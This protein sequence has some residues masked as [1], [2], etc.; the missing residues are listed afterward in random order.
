MDD[1]FGT[2]LAEPTN[3][4]PAAPI[5]AAAAAPI[6]AAAGGLLDIMSGG[7]VGEGPATAPSAP[8]ASPSTND[9]LAD[10]FATAPMPAA[11]PV[12]AAAPVAAAAVAPTGNP[13]NL[14]GGAG[15]PGGA[16]VGSAAVPLQP[17]TTPPAAGLAPGLAGLTSMAPMAP[18]SSNPTVMAFEKGGLKL[19]MVLSKD[20][21]SDP[22]KSEIMCTF[23]NFSGSDFSNFSFQ[24][25]VP[26]F[27]E[28][29]MKPP[30]GNSIAKAGGTLTQI[31]HVKNTQLGT[32]TLMFR[33]KIQYL[34]GM[35]QVAET[36][37]ASGFPAGY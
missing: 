19:T 22:S 31:L 17:T 8:H 4:A 30:S 6:L 9:L 20:D 35:K 14:F 25:A 18:A 16:A 7:G 26:K 23:E 15:I 3:A 5:V 1:L 36:T 29:S 11:A 37:Q 27:I 21:P 34:D 24:T 28:L 12:V 32:K 33:M 13:M 10:I 2:T